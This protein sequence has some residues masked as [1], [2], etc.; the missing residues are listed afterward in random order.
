MVEAYTVALC[1]SGTHL[2][3]QPLKVVC[4]NTQLHDT[5]NIQITCLSSYGLPQASLRQSTRKGRMNSWIDANC[6]ELG[7]ILG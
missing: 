6:P 4:K 1:C 5:C 7:A 2:S 3:P